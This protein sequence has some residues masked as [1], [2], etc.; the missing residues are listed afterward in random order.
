[1]LLDNSHKVDGIK[2]FTH[3]W[4]KNYSALADDI[5]ELEKAFGGATKFKMADLMRNSLQSIRQ[6]F[7]LLNFLEE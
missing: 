2:T 6:N 5:G 7:L 3:T 4:Q 1:M